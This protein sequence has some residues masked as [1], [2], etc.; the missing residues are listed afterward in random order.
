LEMFVP[1]FRLLQAVFELFFPLLC[2]NC[3]KE[4]NSRQK[5]LCLHCELELPLTFFHLI[6]PS[7]LKRHLFNDLKIERV[8]SLYIFEETAL[9]ESLLYQLKYGGNKAIGAF[10][11]QKLAS[12]ICDLTATFDGIIGV[13]L[14]PKRQRKRGFNQVDL[15]GQSAA[16]ALS[17]PYYGTFLERIKRTPK[18]SKASRDRTEILQDAFRINPL[19][20]LPKGHYLLL[21]DILT[22]GA[23][24]K[25][26][27]KLLVKIDH[28]SL[29]IA[30]IVYRN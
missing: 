24:L 21:D 9:I 28:L 30:T 17:I 2:I 20:K 10:F 18:L 27:S 13:P 3:Q 1:L 8:F 6:H 4:I 25:A 19:I 14:H 29:S 15:I 16:N 11:G 23:T 7:P 12:L 5:I 22:T 26:C